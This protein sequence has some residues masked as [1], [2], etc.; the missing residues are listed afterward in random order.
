MS[1]GMIAPWWER[2]WK[3]WWANQQTTLMV[4]DPAGR[5]SYDPSRHEVRWRGRIAATGGRWAIELRWGPGTPFFPPLVYPDGYYSR[6]HQLRDGA[7]CL[8]PPDFNKVIEISDWL[9][10]TRRWLD[11]YVREAWAVTQE[12]WAWISLF[13]P[14]PGYRLRDRP[15]SY[16]LVPFDWYPAALQGEIC[17]CL[18]RKRSWWLEPFLIC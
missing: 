9:V 13:R 5:Y 7:P 2:G 11:R 12:E 16:L 14:D 8:A 6:H 1:Q 17:A 4:E 10:Q 3:D 18:P 15:R